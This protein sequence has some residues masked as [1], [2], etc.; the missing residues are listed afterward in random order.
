M[1]RQRPEKEENDIILS[2]GS[3]RARD[4]QE[5]AVRKTLECRNILIQAPP[6]AG[7]SLIAKL[8][9]LNAGCDIKEAL[10][11]THST[12]LAEQWKTYN[13]RARTVQTL[14][15]YPRVSAKVIILDECHHYET[16]SDAPGAW[17]NIH[18]KIESQYKIGLSA[19]PGESVLR[20]ENRFVIPWKRVVEDGFLSRWKVH[21]HSFRMN[22]EEAMGYASFKP[23][24]IRLLQMLDDPRYESDHEVLER[25]LLMTL[26][27]R[28]AISHES[29]DRPNRAVPIIEEL[30][31]EKTLVLCARQH[32]ADLLA[33]C[34]GTKAFH[35]NNPD[36]EILNA[37]RRGELNIPLKSVVS[38]M[39]K[40]ELQEVVQKLGGD[41]EGTVRQLRERIEK[42][43]GLPRHDMLFAVNMVKEG[44]DVP[45]IDTVII[46]SGASSETSVVQSFG[47]GIRPMEGK[48]C[49]IHVLCARDT[50][51]ERMVE[52]WENVTQGAS[53]NDNVFKWMWKRA[54]RWS[55]LDGVLW[56]GRGMRLA[57]PCGLEDKIEEL[58]GRKNCSV[59]AYDGQIMVQ[60]RGASPICLN[61]LSPID[62]TVEFI[63]L[64]G[65]IR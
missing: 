34:F 7:K 42:Y 9:C 28:R 10:V 33:D 58:M 56:A 37:F 53:T 57:T 64:P 45:E 54:E 60:P 8:V 4:Y 65:G 23:R 20:F 44:F 43:R 27:E 55:L 11:I 5:E 18:D 62:T 29:E 1:E 35:S 16:K 52:N 17:I 3:L 47:R 49:N 38:R 21:H 12:V 39:R 26:T 13:I 6:G 59:R 61:Y 30:C 14:V 32:T 36:K 24:I 25:K 41:W 22:D 48:V 63:K 40:A 15:R 50:S 51:D 31:G 19:T 2:Y 46:V